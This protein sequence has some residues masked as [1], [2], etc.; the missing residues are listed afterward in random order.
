MSR[1][2]IVNELRNLKD[3]M[4]EEE[5]KNYAKEKYDIDEE[6]LATIFENRSIGADY[7]PK[8]LEFIEKLD[9]G[10]GVSIG[11]IFEFLNAYCFECFINLA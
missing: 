7:K 10:S 8:V 2:K 11:K 3:D 5:L 6:T 1:K 4:S 9:D